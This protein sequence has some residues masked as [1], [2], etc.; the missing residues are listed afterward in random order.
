MNSR[1]Q[2]VLPAQP[3]KLSHTT[4]PPDQYRNAADDE[5]VDQAETGEEEDEE[6]E[7]D[8]ADVVEGEDGDRVYLELEEDTEEIKVDE[9]AAR[10]P[11]SDLPGI[12][13]V[14]WLRSR[15]TVS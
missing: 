3:S 6:I 11:V 9:R 7:L 13:F 1:R 5:E 15:F 2:S 8:L 12:H 10:L 4:T 14:S